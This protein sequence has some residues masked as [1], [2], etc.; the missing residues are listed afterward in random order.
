MYDTIINDKD[1]DVSHSTRFISRQLRCGMSTGV[2]LCRFI[3]TRNFFP[4]FPVIINRAN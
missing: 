2:H 1:I 3:W 4:S